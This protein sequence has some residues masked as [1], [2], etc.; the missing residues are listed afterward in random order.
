M[1]AVSKPRQISDD[2]NNA[3]AKPTTRKSKRPAPLSLRLS[4]VE[5]AALEKA[6]DGMSLSRYVKGRI[7]NKDGSPKPSGRAQPVRDHVALAQV[8]GMLGA[9]QAAG[10]FRDLAAAAKSGALP[11]TPETEEEL[12]NACA[13]VL[14]VKAEVMRALGYT[15][16]EAP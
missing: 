6:A 5:R 7:F 10:S 16:V 8:L 9:M 15:D 4:P 1:S 13:A 3:A 14:A 2:F 12:I 11:V